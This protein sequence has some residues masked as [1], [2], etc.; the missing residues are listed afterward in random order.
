MFCCR[1]ENAAA[2]SVVFGI[3]NLDHPSES[4]QIRKVKR[5]ILHPRYKNIFNDYDI[6]VVE[7]HE[8]VIETSYVRPVCLPAK[9]QV[10]EPDTYCFISG[11]GSTGSKGKTYQ[12]KLS[13]KNMM[14]RVDKTLT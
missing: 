6:S 5:I 4:I 3:N 2:W 8:D 7:L 13:I 10:A 9:D 11:W 1:Q 12:C 14:L